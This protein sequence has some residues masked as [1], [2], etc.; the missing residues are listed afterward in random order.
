MNAAICRADV[1]P[2][3]LVASGLDRRGASAPAGSLL[4][5]DHATERLRQ[6]SL[7]QHV[8]DIRRLAV[9]QED[10]GCRWPASDRLDLLGDI[11]MQR[12]VDLIAALAK[13][14]S[15]CDHFFKGQ[16]AVTGQCG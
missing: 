8:A 1:A 16:A 2:V 6:I 10:R 12:R 9:G 7:D 3:E 13:L 14:D 5:C 15:R 4:R 11:P